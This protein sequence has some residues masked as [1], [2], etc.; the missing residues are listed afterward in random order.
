MIRAKTPIALLTVSALALA[1]CMDPGPEPAN[2]NSRAQNGALIGAGL[3]AVLGA[4]RQS[5]SGRVRSAVVGAAVGA[6][7]GA[8]IGNELDKQAEE[9]RAGLGNDVQVVNQGDRLVVTMPQDI[10]FATDSA[11]LRADLQSDLHVLARSLQDYPGTTVDVIGH[12]DNVGDA[13]YNQGLSTRRANSVAAILISRGVSN[14]RV[15]AYGRGEAE[16]VA[17]NLT[18]EGRQQNRRVEIVIW[19]AD[20]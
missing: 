9:L 15:R 8:L 1:G 6:G 14:S 2:G 19:P 7:V 3:G 18:A 13:G 4:T 20:A 16:P 5:G 11:T 17:S 10:L 12:T